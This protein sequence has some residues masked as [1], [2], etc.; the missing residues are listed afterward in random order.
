MDNVLALAYIGDAIFEVE[1]RSFLLNQG[2]VKV[3]ELQEKAVRFV[4]AKSQAFF[5]Q[6]LLQKD[7]FKEE[8]KEIIFRARN[9][10]GN[11]HPK[12]TD[13]LT[14]KHATALEAI[15]GYWYRNNEL[16]RFQQMMEII[17]EKV[18]LD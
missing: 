18:S 3:K 10:K 11:R 17:Y 9:H 13:I 6:E 14:Y 16:E 12:N 15:I 4:S 8:E 1:V 2:I 5:L 7:F